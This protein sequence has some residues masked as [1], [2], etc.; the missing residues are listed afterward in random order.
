MDDASFIMELSA[1]GLLPGDTRS[2]IKAE[3]TQA[4]KASYFLSHVIK[5]ALDIDDSTGFDKLLSIMITCG[6][7]YVCKLAA[8]IKSEVDKPDE[9]TTHRSGS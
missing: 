2:K 1:K 9:K 4:N 5:P 3:S 6:Y 7:D 8:T